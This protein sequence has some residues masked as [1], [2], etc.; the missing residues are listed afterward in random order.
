M[1]WTSLRELHEELS[2]KQKSLSID[3]LQNYET[4]GRSSD[5][6]DTSRNLQ[7]RRAEST[8]TITENEK[9]TDR[10]VSSTGR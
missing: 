8:M 9:K 6:E 5:Y 4:L 10:L 3:S 7:S 2:G 1:R